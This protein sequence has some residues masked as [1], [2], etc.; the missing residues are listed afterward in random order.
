MS[1]FHFRIYLNTDLLTE[2]IAHNP[3]NIEYGIMALVLF[4]GSSSHYSFL[5]TAFQNYSEGY[6]RSINDDH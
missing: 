2:E 5:Q 1:Y 4:V 6:Y 3:I